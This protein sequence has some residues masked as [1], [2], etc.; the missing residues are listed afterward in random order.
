MQEPEIRGAGDLA[1]VGVLA[2]GQQPQERGLARAVLPDQAEAL[3]GGGGQRDAVEDAAVAVGLDE[4]ACEQ[5][6][7]RTSPT[8]ESGNGAR[9]ALRGA[10]NAES[11]R[12]PRTRA[13]VM[14]VLHSG[15]EYSHRVR[16]EVHRFF[17]RIHMVR[18]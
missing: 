3:A 17:L 1:D 14:S 2:A 5:S 13:V 8:E 7:N 16:E 6:G 15:A 9:R 12:G 18:G 4:I 11:A 10:R